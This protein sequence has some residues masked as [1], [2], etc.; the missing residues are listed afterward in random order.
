MNLELTDEHVELRTSTRRFLASKAPVASHVRA[1]LDDPDGTTDEV[2]QGLAAIGA[3]GLLISPDHG[4]SGATMVEAGVVAEELGRALHPRPWIS[5]AVAVPRLLARS[6]ATDDAADL[7]A[8]IAEGSTFATAVIVGTGNEPTIGT[9]SE[10][11]VLTCELP[12]VADAHAAS[13]LVAVVRDDLLLVPLSTVGSGAT[14]LPTVDPTRKRFRVHLDQ[15]PVQVLGTAHGDAISAYLDDL[16][17]AWAADALGAAQAVLDLAVDYAKVRHQ[18]GK[19]IGSFQAVQH[20]C[21]D[22]FET[23]ELARGGVLKGLWAA[24]HGS[25]AQRQRAAVQCKAF[26]GR[27]A[28]VGDTAIQVLG[29][30]GFTWEHDA[31]LYLKRLL[32]WSAFLGSPHGYLRELGASLLSRSAPTWGTSS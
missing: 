10:D 23:V 16:T 12:D 25:A 17:I 13:A 8:G 18:F 29:G 21:V 20:L 6:D 1:M 24:D 5:T 15:V 27:L 30:I 22:M 4:G 28:T 19:P 2:W 32:S 31:H 14:P 26:S 11:V 9:S 7:L 3:T